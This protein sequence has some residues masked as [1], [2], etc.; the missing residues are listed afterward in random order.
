VKG[1][2]S[3]QVSGSEHAGPGLSEKQHNS[4]LNKAKQRAQI[5]TCVLENVSC[6]Q[7]HKDRLITTS[8]VT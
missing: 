8:S 6:A 7:S 4:T 1:S 5:N 3:I 2:T